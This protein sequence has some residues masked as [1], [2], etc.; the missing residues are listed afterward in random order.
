MARM[1]IAGI[2]CILALFALGCATTMSAPGGVEK[3][4]GTWAN[5][6]YF[7]SYWTHTFTMYPDGR[8]LWWDQSNVSDPT[9]ESRFVIDEKWV[10]GQGNTWYR[11]TE[12]GSYLPYNEEVARAN[13]V[14]SLL[15]IDASGKI[16]EG[17]W[18]KLASPKE[19]GA[20][21]NTHFVYFRQL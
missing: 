19:F 6:E 9:G 17:E 3:L 4:H 11:L 13:A 21:G 2:L 5:K 10:D 15:R 12:R 14:Y 16:L 18:S 8:E 20:L 1:R 7:G